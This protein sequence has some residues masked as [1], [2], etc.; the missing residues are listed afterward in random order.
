MAIKISGNTVIDDS[1]NISVSGNA[2]ANSFVGD[3]SNLTNL[4]GGGNVTEV[5]ASGTLSDGSTVIVNTDGTVSVVSQT[6]SETTG[7]GAETPTLIRST[8]VDNTASVYDSTNQKVIIVYEDTGNGS[9]GTAIVGTVSGTTISF[10]TPVVFN[11][12]H[13]NYPSIAYDSTSNKVVV[14][15]SNAGNSSYGTAIVGTVSGTSISFGS[16]VVFKSAATYYVSPTYDSA[17]NKVVI[18]YN[19]STGKAIVG[20]VSGTSISFGTEVEFNSSG[21][22]LYI[23]STFDS[24][25][26]KVVIAYRD[27]G[28]SNYGTAI[29]GTVSGT[30]ISFGSES[31][32]ESAQANYMSAV[33]DSSNQKV[34]IAY[35][36]D[37]NSNYGTA[38]VG[39]VSGTSISFGS[40]VIFNSS[41][42]MEISAVFDSSNNKVAIAYRGGSYPSV[43]G[44]AIVGTVSGTSISF[45]SAVVFESADSWYMSTAYDST[46]QKVVIAY[47]D[48]G[49]SYYATAAVFSTTGFSIPQVGSLTNFYEVGGGGGDPPNVAYDPVNDKVIVVHR[50]DSNWYLY[51]TVGT[52]S[53]TSISFG[54]PVQIVSHVTYYNQIVYDANAD[55][56]VI[57]WSR[58]GSGGGTSIVAQVSGDTVTVGSNSVFETDNLTNAMSETNNWLVYDPDSQKVVV[59]YVYDINN[60]YGRSKIGT[61][62]PSTNSISWSSGDTWSSNQC[63]GPSLVYDTNENK[64]VVFYQDRSNSRRLSA[65]VGT[66][67]GSGTNITWSSQ[68][69]PEA[70]YTGVIST[71][72]LPSIQKIL[73]VYAKSNAGSP[74]WNWSGRA[75][76]GTVSGTSISFGSPIEWISNQ[77]VYMDSVYDS[78]KQN[79]VLIYRD[80]SNDDGI[81]RPITIS[82]TTPSFGDATTFTGHSAG[83]LLT[84][85]TGGNN[86]IVL[87]DQAN[88]NYG[89]AFVYN[90][91]TMVTS[92]NLTSEN[93]IGISDGAFTDGQ[94]ATIQL[95]G[96]VD[97]AQSSLTPGQK[98]YVQDDGTLAESGSVFAG[99]AVS[100]TSLVVKS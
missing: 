78:N 7:A 83:N 24:T 71:A 48:A 91:S 18:A 15:Y 69:T 60:E 32:F 37:G 38:V 51:A 14:A 34:V 43:Y 23:A 9:A 25:N 95:I 1:Q 54:T 61:V 85:T 21:E 80:Q 3:G 76:V 66:M 56:F 30:S 42:T 72:Y 63:G 20:T 96:S 29:V 98:Y 2:T 5:T 52:V 36:D 84:H 49:N 27:L 31:V 74:D 35:Q 75:I 53:G 97:D 81:L 89:R 4:P 39:T 87:E 86:V 17:N 33:Y 100:S 55:R 44:T 68:Q 46:N 11:S 79:V 10:G 64:F 67:N 13:T 8:G 28:N 82:G 59:T 57:A 22:S 73:I 47:G 99:T 45:G 26:N 93:Y 12:A 70:V 90:Q 94:T 88:S 16:A 65:K 62:D 41:V 50:G 6:T 58:L 92:T 19:A 40:P 77:I